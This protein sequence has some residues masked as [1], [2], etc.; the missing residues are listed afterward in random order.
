LTTRKET[1]QSWRYYLADAVFLVIISGKK[2]LLME[3]RDALK[4]PECPYFLGRKS[5][6]PT[7]PVLVELT[8]QYSSIMETIENY[9][10]G[11]TTKY[12]RKKKG[13]K[14]PRRIRYVIDDTTGDKFQTDKIKTGSRMYEPRA[15][16]EGWIDAPAEI[17]FE[18]PS[19]HASQEVSPDTESDQDLTQNGIDDDYEA[20]QAEM[21][22]NDFDEFYGFDTVSNNENEQ[23]GGEE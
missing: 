20:S 2:E 11:E 17:I 15:F 10:Y 3:I 23:N 18:D 7:A 1:I 22:S 4:N 8:E 19:Q 12:L 9:P 6:V 21:D 14:A 13:K 16:K 5:C